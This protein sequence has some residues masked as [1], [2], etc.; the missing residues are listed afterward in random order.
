MCSTIALLCFLLS[1]TN[2]LGPKP[3]SVR[4]SGIAT[5]KPSTAGILDGASFQSWVTAQANNNVKTVALQQ[6]AYHV[7]PSGQ[8]SAHIFLSG[9]EDVTIWMDDVNLTMTN[10]GYQAF[11]FYQNSNVVTFGPTVWWDIPGFSQA[12]ITSVHSLDSTG[13][14]FNITF[15]PDDGYDSSFLLNPDTGSVNGDYTDPITGRLQAGPGWST[16]QGM[17]TK[18][19]NNSWTVPLTNFYFYPVV[20]FKLLARG[21]FL[22]CNLIADCKNT[23][24]NDFTLLNCGGFGFMSNLNTRTTFN[25]LSIRPAAFPPPGGTELPV[26]SSSADGIHSADDFIGPTFDS[27]LFDALDDDAMAIH[28]T[29]RVI[30]SISNGSSISSPSIISATKSSPSSS[31]SVSLKDISSSLSATSTSSSWPC[32]TSSASC[33]SGPS[34]SP[35]QLAKLASG[36]SSY[37]LLG[38]MK[39]AVS[40]NLIPISW[41]ASGGGAIVDNGMTIEECAS[42]ASGATYFGLTIGVQCIW[43]PSLATSHY[44]TVP[45]SSCNSICLGNSSEA[46]GAENLLQVYSSKASDSL[47]TVDAKV[48]PGKII[49]PAMGSTSRWTYQGCYQY[50][51][52]GNLGNYA[53]ATT[54]EG[55]ANYCSAQ[56]AAAMSLHYASYCY[57]GYMEVCSA[58]YCDSLCQAPCVGNSSEACGSSYYSVVY[59]LGAKPASVSSSSAASAILSPTSTSNKSGSSTL[60]PSP[61]SSPSS[62]SQGQGPVSFTASSGSVFIG[63]ILRFYSASGIWEPL[64]TARVTK[65]LGSNPI[66]ITVDNMPF[67]VDVTS[68][69]VNTNQTGSGFSITNTEVNY[70]C[71]YSSICVD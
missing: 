41:Q 66:N 45:V 61:S 30:S 11:Q 24:V 44:A 35:T 34:L 53:G 33:N 12:T 5:Y 16:I 69:W 25:S 42:K 38:C 27:C 36:S 59:S 28:G 29:L 4:P 47:L 13:Q 2:A 62:T 58:Q 31:H 9:L 63:A 32:S 3:P 15:R 52:N 14:N 56:G 19:E 71:C 55:C 43:G 67:G 65:I 10:T 46:C 8:S 48:T 7:T 68:S 50:G 49:N 18:G 70:L 21:N 6:G 39:I 64:G 40:E 54:I 17:A 22:F 1:T 60:S 57:C 51:F 23:V 20:G 26:R 37:K